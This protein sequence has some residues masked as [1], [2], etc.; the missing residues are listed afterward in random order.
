MDRRR[1]YAATLAE[2]ER[3]ELAALLGRK[4]KSAAD[5]LRKLDT[6]IRKGTLDDASTLR[7]LTRRAFRDE[8]L[9]APAVAL[10]PQRSWSAID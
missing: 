7:Y 2:I 3:D 6:A 9:Y 5:G 1:R 10:Y 8:W 4:P